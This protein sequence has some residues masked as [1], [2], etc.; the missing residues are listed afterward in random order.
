MTTVA[1]PAVV[2]Y[3]DVDVHFWLDRMGTSSAE[4]GFRVLST[5]GATVFAEGRRV[6]IRV[7]PATMR[8]TPWTAPGRATG[9]ALL[10]S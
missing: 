2:P 5:D 10:R 3:G 8:P 4:Y 7:D 9:A 1:E 6:N